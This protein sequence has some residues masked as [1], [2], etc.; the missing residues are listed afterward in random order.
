MGWS[1]SHLHA[2]RIG[3]T[4]YSVPDPENSDTAMS[5]GNV[6][7]NQVVFQGRAKGL[8]QSYLNETNLM[9]FDLT[10]KRIP[11]RLYDGE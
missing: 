5:E 3:D 6:R 10:C 4:V 8:G 1:D 9:P 2:F 11:T 7:L